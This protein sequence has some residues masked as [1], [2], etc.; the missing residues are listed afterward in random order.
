MSG[1]EQ[2]IVGYRKSDRAKL[3]ELERE[4]GLRA[5]RY[6]G[7]INCGEEVCFVQSGADAI[8]NRDPHPICD[9]CW[10]QP[11]VKASIYAEL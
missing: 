8:R 6:K 5:F 3:G 1:L 9:V 11:D 2:L 7:C 10:A 4:H